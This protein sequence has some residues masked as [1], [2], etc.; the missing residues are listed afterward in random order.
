ML[1]PK[2]KASFVRKWFQ[3]RFILTVLD[4]SLE[5]VGMLTNI[6]E[7]K[8][9]FRTVFEWVSLQCPFSFNQEL[10]YCLE[11]LCSFCFTC[12]TQ[13]SY[14]TARFTRIVNRDHK[15]VRRIKIQDFPVGKQLVQKNYCCFFG[16]NTMAVYFMGRISAN[17]VW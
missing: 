2:Q 6:S 16:Q 10:N 1:L 15:T 5:T 13:T 12:S 11:Y 9:W 4:H 17:V 7:R 8:R 14:Q 3:I